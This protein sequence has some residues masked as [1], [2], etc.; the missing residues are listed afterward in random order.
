MTADAVRSAASGRGLLVDYGG[1]LTSSAADAFRAFERAEGLPKGTVFEVIAEAYR[2]HGGDSAIAKFERGDSTAAEFGAEF[3]ALLRER[4]H[5]VDPDDIH[6]R[7]FSMSSFADE[8]WTVVGRAREA[9]VRTALLS[10]SW[11]TDHYPVERLQAHFD[12]IVVSGEVGLRKPDPGIYR[13]TAERIGLAPTA[14][15]FVD[16]LER[17][18]EAAR[19]VGMFGVHHT[20]DVE[21][22]ASLLAGFLGVDLLASP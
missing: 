9:G 1:V 15:A 13:L 3:S 14:C 12:A 5:D 17:N 2:H 20:G 16:D 10:N 19:E 4:G 6:V 21:E 18:V 22:T 11:G 8:M 7:I